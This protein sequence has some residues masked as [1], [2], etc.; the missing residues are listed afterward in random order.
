MKKSC[1]IFL[2]VI[3]YMV[4]FSQIICEPSNIKR[5]TLKDTVFK[6]GDIILSPNIIFALSGSS[7]GYKPFNDS[8]AVVANFLINHPKLKVQLCGHTDSRGNDQ[9]NLLVSSARM[10]HIKDAL[11]SYYKIDAHRVVVLGYGEYC[12]IMSK[13]IIN[14][15][16][17]KEE[18]EKLYSINRRTEIK[19]LN[20]K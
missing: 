20:D 2:F 18:K 13:K 9:K 15:A 17:T 14:S 11:I 16:K 1:A 7:W 4:S 12:P 3:V 5:K 8:V 6:T 10:Q 19:I